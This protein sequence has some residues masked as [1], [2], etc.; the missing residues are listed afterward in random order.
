MRSGKTGSGTGG[1]QNLKKSKAVAGSAVKS[2]ADQAA[3]PAAILAADS[4]AKPA[5]EAVSSSGVGPG[6]DPG[7]GSHFLK[8]PLADKAAA[9]LQKASVSVGFDKKLAAYDLAGSLAHAKMLSQRGLLTSKEFEEISRGLGKLA[10]QIEDDAFEWDEELEDVHMNLEKA[11]TDLIGPSGG[12]LHT[13]RSRNDQVA[14]DERLYLLDAASKIGSQLR[15]LRLA[16]LNRARQVED[17]PM[18]GYT[19]LQRAQPVL[20]A[21]HLLAYYHMLTR[22]QQR[23][24]DLRP[25]L[26]VMPLGSGALAGSGLPIEPQIV[27]EILNFD[28]LSANSLDAV[29]SRDHLLEFL[30]FGAILMTHL[31]RMAEE[32]VLW[33]TSEFG[34]ISLPDSLTTTSSMMPHKKNPDG[35]ELIRGKAGRTFG[36]L[37]ALLT[38]VKGLPLAYNRDLQEDKE[39]LFDTVKT[40]DLVLPLATS[41]VSSM[42][43]NFDRLRQAA[44]DPYVAATDLADHL[45][46]KGTPFRQAHRRVGE[47]VA[48]AVSKGVALKDLPRKLLEKHCPEADESISS[49]LTLEHLLEAR[50]T[51][52][53]GT[54]PAAVARQLDIAFNEIEGEKEDGCL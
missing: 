23:L 30:S 10:E 43:F 24:N 42:T 13:A 53:G 11:L 12:K 50:C 5:S 37:M 54:A 36:N 51:S 15:E 16:L 40:L 18:P 8:G 4:A 21:H 45:V 26:N 31:S 41:L 9:S 6:P 19:H 34:F 27:A 44:D 48:E 25:R 20:L 22:D 47:L 33:C 52:P 14:L 39:P 35:A 49:K 3:N 17:A 32:I 1:A 2:V 7:P 29:A 46:V 38:T 28:K